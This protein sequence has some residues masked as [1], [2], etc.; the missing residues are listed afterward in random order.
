MGI[1]NVLSILGSP[2]DWRD[3]VL[4][5]KLIAD[6]IACLTDEG[7]EATDDSYKYEYD[8]TNDSECGNQSFLAI[9]DMP[10]KATV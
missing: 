2:R 5:L 8:M 6:Q 4:S 10:K 3:S 9:G 1:N 7:I